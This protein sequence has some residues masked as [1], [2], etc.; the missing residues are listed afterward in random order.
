MTKRSEEVKVLRDHGIPKISPEI[1]GYKRPGWMPFKRHLSVK[2]PHLAEWNRRRQD[3]ARR[4][5]RHAFPPLK[6]SLFLT[7]PNGHARL[8]LYVIRGV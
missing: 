6:T 1:E 7:S 2:L 4:L 3:A 5:R 8:S